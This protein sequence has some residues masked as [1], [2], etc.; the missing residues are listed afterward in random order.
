MVLAFSTE[1]LWETAGF[2][3]SGVLVGSGLAL[4][5]VKAVEFGVGDAARGNV[6]DAA[7]RERGEEQAAR[8]ALSAIEARKASGKR[9]RRC[10]VSSCDR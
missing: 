3:G 6:G 8:L 1:R 2:S 7:G 5:A 10:M 9:A 4:N